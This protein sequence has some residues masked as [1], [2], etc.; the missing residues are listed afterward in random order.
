MNFVI[1]WR[2]KIQKVI[3]FIGPKKM[4]FLF[5]SYLIIIIIMII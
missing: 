3:T 4:L 5:I 2:K 1:F